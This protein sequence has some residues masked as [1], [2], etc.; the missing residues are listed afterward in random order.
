MMSRWQGQAR[1]LGSLPDDT[2]TPASS[3]SKARTETR[4]ST[5][6]ELLY[7]TRHCSEFQ[8]T[9]NALH[10][11]L[12]QRDGALMHKATQ[13]SLPFKAQGVYNHV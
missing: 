8:A 2:N 10:E 5:H 13:Y 7:F 4:H 6:L 1:L 9:S 12:L 11:G 3:V